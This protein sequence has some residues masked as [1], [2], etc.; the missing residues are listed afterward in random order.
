[1]AMGDEPLFLDSQ[2]GLYENAITG[3][4]DNAVLS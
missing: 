2:F 4:F 1:M 3:A